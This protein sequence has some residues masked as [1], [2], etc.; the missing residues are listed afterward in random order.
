MGLTSKVVYRNT[1]N[2][3]KFITKSGTQSLRDRR[4]RFALFIC[5]LMKRL[6]GSDR[7]LHDRART[8]IT[9]CI[10]TERRLNQGGKKHRKSTL[11]ETIEVSL[12]EVVGEGH[13]IRTHAYMRYYLNT[14]QP[15]KLLKSKAFQLQPAKAP[16]VEAPAC[17]GVKDTTPTRPSWLV[18]S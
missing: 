10:A 1:K 12:R 4:S 8:L 13:W 7:V 14:Y 3:G 16:V 17:R 9:A 15:R 5:I 2:V 6:K 11:M 18:L